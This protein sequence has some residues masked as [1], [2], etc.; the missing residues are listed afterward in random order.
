MFL[1]SVLCILFIVAP[2]HSPETQGWWHFLLAYEAVLVLTIG[3]GAITNLAKGRLSGWP[4]GAM[5]CGYFMSLWLIPLA[6][7][8]IVALVREQKR[9]QSAK[10]D[11]Q[12]RAP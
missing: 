5:I 12:P 11:V 1:V 9:Q 2:G 3:G 7:W 8:G 10:P 6:I 4:P